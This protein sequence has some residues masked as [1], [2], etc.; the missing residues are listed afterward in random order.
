MK[1]LLAISN[2][3]N[4]SDCDNG[5]LYTCISVSDLFKLENNAHE[6]FNLNK[7]FNNKVIYICV[8]C[9]RIWSLRWYIQMNNLEY[10]VHI[11]IK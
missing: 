2:M 9:L 1:N 4:I 3:N 11:Y 6:I 5:H 8:Y 10:G 7:V